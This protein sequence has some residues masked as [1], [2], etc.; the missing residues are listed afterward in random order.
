MENGGG[1]PWD[2]AL[3]DGAHSFVWKAGADLLTLLAARPGER[4]LDLGCGTGH[5]T[6]QIAESGAAV[7]GV[8]SSAAMIEEARRAYPQLRFELGDAMGLRVLEPFDAVFSNAALHWMT[9]PADVA[10]SVRDALKPGGRF[11]FEM[12]GHGNMAA[13]YGALERAIVRAGLAPVPLS[14]FLYFPTLGAQAS[15]LEAHGFRV[16]YAAHF[17]RP[18][19]L[20]GGDSGLTQWIAMFGDR[21]LAAV[22]A[23]VRQAVV[24]EVEAELRP[25][26]YRDGAWHADY[27]R[28]RAAATRSDGPG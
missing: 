9:R 10:A 20:E 16:T 28:L 14:A 13:V 17:D 8:D 25:Q 2:P 11:V 23:A 22:P 24:R 15:L 27:V 1:K 21:F 6:R 26:L 18:T 19:R 4:V 7:V 5:L 12:G 3:Y